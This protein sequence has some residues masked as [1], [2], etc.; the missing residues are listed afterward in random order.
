MLGE[1]LKR[2]REERNLTQKEV[3]AQL[4]KSVQAY[5]QYELGKREPDLDTLINLADF[6]QLSLDN[7]IGRSP[8]SYGSYFYFE[9]LKQSISL[10]SLAK[11]EDYIQMICL[12]ESVTGNPA[13]KK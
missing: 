4:H 13:A 12:C 6:Y 1:N 7:L 5:S 11:I 10:K 9:D 8:K 3:A 2:L